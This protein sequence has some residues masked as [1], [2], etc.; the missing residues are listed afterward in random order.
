[1]PVVLVAAVVPVVP[2][3]AVVVGAKEESVMIKTSSPDPAVK[4][5]P[6]YP[7]SRSPCV[8]VAVS[9][10][11]PGLVVSEETVTRL[12]APPVV[13]VVVAIVSSPSPVE[14]SSGSN[15]RF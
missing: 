12:I 4:V 1:V 14:P 3:V 9:V 11:V 2:V 7:T 13:E 10:A 8:P 5:S 15:A 6:G